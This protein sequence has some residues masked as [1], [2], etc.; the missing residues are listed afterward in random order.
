MSGRRG[1][2]VE[3]EVMQEEATELFGYTLKA[4]ISESFGQIPFSDDWREPKVVHVGI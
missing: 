1:S 3:V 2:C 4:E